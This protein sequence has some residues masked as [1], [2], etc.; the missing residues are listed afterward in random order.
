MT[1]ITH[2]TRDRYTIVCACGAHPL[3]NTATLS[4]PAG[5]AVSLLKGRKQADRVHGFVTLAH[6]PVLSRAPQIR[7]NGPWAGDVR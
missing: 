4:G 7:A 2:A 3:G 5:R 6:H 1:T